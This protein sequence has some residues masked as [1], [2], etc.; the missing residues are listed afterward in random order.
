V[1]EAPTHT[2]LWLNRLGIN[3]KTT[4]NMRGCCSCAWRLNASTADPLQSAV[5][6]PCIATHQP[7]QAADAHHHVPSKG[8]D[9]ETHDH[10]LTSSTA[11]VPLVNA[12]ATVLPHGASRTRTKPDTPPSL[13]RTRPPAKHAYPCPASAYPTCLA[14]VQCQARLPTNRLTQP[15]PPLCH[16]KASPAMPTLGAGIAAAP[17]RDGSRVLSDDHTRTVGLPG[18]V[19]PAVRRVPRG[20]R[21]EASRAQLG[22]TAAGSQPCHPISTG[23]TCALSCV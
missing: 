18:A 17:A 14:D 3:K 4:T 6:D 1:P 23:S 20:R 21:P 13:G 8:D 7:L 5:G 15:S 12:Q 16:P 19:A 2:S 22:V 9:G 11:G 10:F